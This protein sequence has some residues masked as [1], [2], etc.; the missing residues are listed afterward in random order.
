MFLWFWLALLGFILIQPIL[1]KSYEHQALQAR[2]GLEKGLRIA[3][4]L[5]LASGYGFFFFW[6]GIWIAPQPSFEIPFLQHILFV[7]PLFTPYLSW[8]IPLLHFLLGLAFLVPGGWLGLKGMTELTLEVSETHY[9]RKI[10]TS[11]I[12]SRIRHPQ[13]LGGFLSHI[14]MTLLLSSWFSLLCTPVVALVIYLL[15][16]REER[17]LVREFGDVYREYREKVPMFFPRLH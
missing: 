16:R 7:I 5:G 10:I 8:K 11:G 4:M 3:K 9:P 2:Y 13:Y 15:C 6:I 14:G 17:E 1:Y 12:Y